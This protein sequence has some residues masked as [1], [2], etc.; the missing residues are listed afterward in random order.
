MGI[1]QLLGGAVGMKS[2]TSPEK[3]VGEIEKL[4]EANRG[5]TKKVLFELSYLVGRA[6]RLFEEN[7]D[8]KSLRSYVFLLEDIATILSQI[9]LCLKL[10]DNKLPID[11]LRKVEKITEALHKRKSEIL[12][13]ITG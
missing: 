11:I 1:S 3:I 9:E 12:K 2:A 7:K 5:V 4:A 8:P 13:F 10:I 6:N